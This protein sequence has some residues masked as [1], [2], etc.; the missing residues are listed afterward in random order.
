MAVYVFEEKR[1]RKET[2]KKEQSIYVDTVYV[3]V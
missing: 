3:Y 1:G 2:G